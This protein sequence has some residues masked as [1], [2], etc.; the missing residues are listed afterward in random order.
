MKFTHKVFHLEKDVEREN[1][2]KSMNEYIS[3]YSSELD[4]PTIE[5]SC[6]EDLEKFYIDSNVRFT[7]TGYEFD[8]QIG[9]RFGELGVWASNIKAYT[10]FLET[11]ADFLILMEDDIEYFLGF[12]E[13]LV[14]YMS[15]LPESWDAFFYFAPDNGNFDLSYESL[16][17]DLG[18]SDICKTYQDWS[19]LCYVINRDTARKILIDINRPISLPLDYYFFRQ[20]DKYNSYTVKTTSKLYCRIAKMQSTFQHK[21]K[22]EV[23]S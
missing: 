12:Y 22:R 23:L 15:Q 13:N 4:T 8:N 10:K 14:Y 2:Y 9:W 7:N 3:Q 5:I 21:Q 19:C 17:P 16:M 11:D 6:K 1:L 20:P 18:K